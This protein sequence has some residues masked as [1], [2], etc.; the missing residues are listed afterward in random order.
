MPL[1]AL[2]LLLSTTPTTVAE[3]R[4]LFEAG[5]ADFAAGHFEAALDAFDHAY[6][7]TSAPGLLFD[8]GQCHKALHHWQLAS[9]FFRLYLRGKPVDE[10]GHVHGLIAE[11]DAQ[12]K[13]EADARPKTAAPPPQ[14]AAPPPPAP[15]PTALPPAVVAEP[16]SSP[17]RSNRAPWI[18]VSSGSGLAG[19]GAVLGILAL[20]GAHAL[21]ATDSISGGTTESS[22][23]Q[24]QYVHQGSQV[25]TLA[26]ISLPLLVVGVATVASG[27][28]WKL[29][30]KSRPA[31]S[32]LSVDK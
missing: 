9:K 5:S 16:A 32:R 24:S 21:T 18:V 12:A 1:A 2:M 31:H 29:E 23:T 28:I 4:K 14:L 7:L 10:A 22:L 30:E 27:L 20:S 11:A 13:I 8:I 25:D 26:S 17:V 6:G 19:I 15:A 3:A